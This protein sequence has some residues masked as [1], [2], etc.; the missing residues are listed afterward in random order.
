[1]RM[2]FA[3]FILYFILPVF[4]CAQKIR[5]ACVGNSITYGAFIANREKKSYPA[6]LQAYLGDKYIV[7]NFGLSGSTVLEKGN[8]PYIHSKEFKSSLEFKPD[9]IFIKLGTND[10]KDINWKYSDEFKSDY[11][12][13][14][15]RYKELNANSRII[16]LLPIRCYLPIT[17]NRI[18][19]DIIKTEIRKYIEEIA[20]EENLEIV[21]LYNLFD[22]KWDKGIIPD[23]IHPSSIGAGY[24]AERLYKYIVSSNDNATNICD[25]LFT[26]KSNSIFSFHGYKAI[27]FKTDNRKCFIVEPKKI[28]KGYP[29]VIRAR[30]W[31]HEPQTDIAL[32][33]NGFHLAYCD[34]SDMYGSDYA[35]K[36]WDKF[37][38]IMIK[39][40]LSK[41]VVLEGMSRG[42]L[43]VYNWASKNPDK[44][45]C[46]YADA[47]VMDIKSWPL[48]KNKNNKSIPDIKKLLSAYNFTS[49]NEAIRWN[50]NPL[51][52]VKILAKHQIPI[53]HVVG[54]NDTVVPVDENT[55]IFEEQM[56]KE[57]CKIT[58]I[59]KA[60]I[61]HHPHSLFNP[62]VIVDFILKHTDKYINIC[63]HAVPGNEYRWKDAGWEKD[64]D[65]Y[66]ISNEITSLLKEE[67]IEF[68]FLGNSITQGWGGERK[69]VLRK[70]GRDILNAMLKN[71]TWECA[72]ISGD[73]TQN[74]IW[75]LKYGNYNK[76]NPKVSIICIGINNLISGDSTE[77]VAD[78]ILAVVNEAEK[79]LPKTK[80]ILLGVLPAGKNTNDNLNKRCA[81]V[82]R[83]L[84]DKINGNILYINPTQWFTD[85][86]G[87]LIEKYFYSDF[88][89][90]SPMGYKKWSEELNKL[91]NNYN[92]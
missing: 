25:S 84:L 59:H 31:D 87:N 1:M 27:E 55:A 21:N 80:H 58:V 6:Q 65:W 91:I 36:L 44:V 70:P 7:K 22:D 41:K 71:R 34:V 82:H 48:G 39:I 50:K 49:E 9:I 45:Q 15:K 61:G 26:D 90:L 52:H 73:R 79:Q 76:C 60:G 29:W 83:I 12:K 72:G 75:R 63:T 33:E 68:L 78:G 24:I 74:L 64:C 3:L 46:I 19:N 38:D 54:D 28:A 20:F 85:N 2:K 30:F 11:K 13:I 37:Y 92:L 67:N 42:G 88:I 51:N 56:R 35:I 5:V 69:L 8:L 77:D 47:P 23:K 43:I 16:L 17:N 62:K 86:D 32:L 40:G 18:N 53:I 14:I 4:M 10:S 57:G 89:H 81:Q 66:K